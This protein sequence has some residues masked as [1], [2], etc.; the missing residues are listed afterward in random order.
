[1]VNFK[2]K[3]TELPQYNLNGTV[4]LKFKINTKTGWIKE[5]LLD[6]KLKGYIEVNDNTKR[7]KISKRPLTIDNRVMI[8]GY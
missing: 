6:Q 3:S 4:K 1:M 8:S 7:I 5:G 2:N